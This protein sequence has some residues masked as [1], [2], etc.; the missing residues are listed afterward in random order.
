MGE[1]PFPSGKGNLH[2]AARERLQVSQQDVAADCL[3]DVPSH[4]LKRGIGLPP[5]L[6]PGVALGVL[7]PVDRKEEL[8]V[9]HLLDPAAVDGADDHGAQVGSLSL[10]PRDR[11]QLFV[12]AGSGECQEIVAHLLPRDQQIGVRKFSQIIGDVIQ[13]KAG[14]LGLIRQILERIQ[15]AVDDLSLSG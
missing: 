2:P 9:V 6:V 3:L 10:L 14:Q 5:V 1:I 15:E 12:Q 11:I 13:D 8:H 7:A 4:R